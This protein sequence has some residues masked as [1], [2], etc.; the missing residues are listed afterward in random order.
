MH[1]TSCVR[2]DSVAAGKSLP[3]PFYS[4]RLWLSNARGS[5]PVLALMPIDHANW[6]TVEKRLD[7]FYCLCKEDL[8]RVLGDVPD[9]RSD[10]CIRQLPQRMIQRQ[11]L[12]IKHIEPGAGDLLIL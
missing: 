5:R 1:V 2:V 11:R 4:C 3:A 6:R 10:D 7:I 9:M 8:V 12:F